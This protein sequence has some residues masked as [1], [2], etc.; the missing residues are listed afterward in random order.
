MYA[1]SLT[2]RYR[3]AR[4]F[5]RTETVSLPFAVTLRCVGG[6]LATP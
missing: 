1:D 5:E 3:Y 6:P 2:L 4:W